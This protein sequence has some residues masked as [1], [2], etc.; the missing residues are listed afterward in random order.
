VCWSEIIDDD[1][2]EQLAKQGVRC[3]SIRRLSAAGAFCGLV[4]R[5]VPAPGTFHRRQ[6]AAQVL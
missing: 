2:S 5:V 4:S 1:P 3:C 6:R